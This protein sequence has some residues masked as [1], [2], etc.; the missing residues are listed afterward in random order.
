MNVPAT[1]SPTPAPA[2]QILTLSDRWKSYLILGPAFASSS[3]ID[4]LGSRRCESLGP[5]FLSRL[6]LTSAALLPLLLPGFL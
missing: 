3:S 2:Q 5:V 4:A 6:R 1:V